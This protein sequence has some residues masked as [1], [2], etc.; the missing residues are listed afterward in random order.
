MQKTTALLLTGISLFIISCTTPIENVGPWDL[1]LLFQAPE[2]E[3]TDSA[4]QPGMTGI[5]YESIPYKNKPV[6]VFAYY[7]TPEGDAPEGGW[8]AVVCVHGG[9]GTA[10]HVWVQEWN[11]RGFAAISMDLEGHFPLRINGEK[12]GPRVPTPAPGPKR[13]G[14]FGD[15]DLP[16]EEQWYYHAVSQVILAHSLIRSFPEVNPEKTGIT[17]ISWGGTLTSTN[18]GVDTRYKFAIPVYGCGYLPDSDGHQGDAIQPAEQTRIV[19]TY[20]DGSAYFK[21]VTIPTLWV[22][23]TN[24]RH[25]SMP[26]TRL[27][28]RAVK[29]PAI[30]RYEPR[31]RHGHYPGWEPEEIYAFAKSVVQNGEALIAFERPEIQENQAQVR[32]SYTAS[33]NSVQAELHYTRDTGIWNQRNWEAAP[34]SVAGSTILATIPEGTVALFF[35]ASENRGLKTSSEYILIK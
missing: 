11:S 27:S 10:F 28:S 29:G 4:A 9:G 8:P 5:L 25:F 20:F 12:R 6:Q 26:A 24:D 17:G 31:M 23:G 7:S 18:M 14:V 35:T 30:L 15:Y 16:M 33:E 3:T 19:Y 34:A 2:W 22:N 32:V 13:V 1:S 21:R